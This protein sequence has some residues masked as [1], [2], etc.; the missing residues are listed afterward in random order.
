MVDTKIFDSIPGPLTPLDPESWQHSLGRI[1]DPPLQRRI[2]D[3]PEWGANP[4]G[5]W[6]G[7]APKYYLLKTA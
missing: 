3:F 5:E 6:G 2:Q 1:L 4:K 7:G